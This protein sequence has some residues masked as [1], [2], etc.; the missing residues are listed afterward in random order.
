M[1]LKKNNERNHKILY[2]LNDTNTLNN[3]VLTL[4]NSLSELFQKYKSVK[5]KR[6][7]EEEKERLLSNRLKRLKSKEKQ[8]SK[9]KDK[10]IKMQMHTDSSD[11]SKY[12]FRQMNNDVE[13]KEIFTENNK[14]DMPHNNS[15]K[16]MNNLE[17]NECSDIL[18]KIY[19]KKE[20]NKNILNEL[21]NNFKTINPTNKMS[22]I[23]NNIDRSFNFNDSFKKEILHHKRIIQ[24]ISNGKKVKFSYNFNSIRKYRF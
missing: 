4:N 19:K 14:N 9:K 1:K 22:Y 24:V 21:D 17:L 6:K 8:L 2:E 23:T 10:N 7:I 12:T 11:K 15:M 5:T 16:M 3:K 13:N 18:S 20:R